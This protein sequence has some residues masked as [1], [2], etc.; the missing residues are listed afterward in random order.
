MKK[1]QRDFKHFYDDI[2]NR[3]TKSRSADATLRYSSGQSLDEKVNFKDM[4]LRFCHALLY[5]V[6]LYTSIA[7]KYTNDSGNLL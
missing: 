1:R 5:F 7:W 2:P 3:R 6:M 4:N